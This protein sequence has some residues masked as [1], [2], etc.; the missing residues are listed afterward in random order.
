MASFVRRPGPWIVLVLLVGLG[1]LISYRV[2]QAQTPPDPAPTV[3]QIREERGLPVTVASAESGT[4][5]V[6][7]EYSGDVSGIRDAVVRARSEDQVSAVLVS[8]GDRVR[9]GQVLVRQAGEVA[10]ARARQAQAALRQAERTVERL[11]PLHEAGAISE[12]DWEN[13]Q[14]QLELAQGDVAAAGDALALTSPLAGTVTEVPGRAG[15]IPRSGDPL[16]VVADLSRLLVRLRVSATQAAEIREGQPARLA[17]R[18]DAT[19][20][21][22]RLALQAEAATR[23]VEVEVEFP[24]ETGLIL[25]TLT[26]VELRVA[27][28]PDAVVVPRAALRDD[29]VWVVDDD[30]AVR[31][32]VQVGLQ[33]RDRVE[34]R[35]GVQPGDRVVVA[36]ASLLSDG[37]RVRVVNGA[38]D[39]RAEVR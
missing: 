31:R 28:R 29:V 10:G 20:R 30:R 11:R 25:G 32:D 35:S 17:G 26:T 12:Q 1:G 15:M 13:A 4:F 5:E 3:E 23:L 27:A 22:R 6:W 18:D 34:I 33:G 16:V 38:G 24:R 9:Q 14:T 39:A 37:A 21:V 7:R 36:G 19:G 2:Q 8:V